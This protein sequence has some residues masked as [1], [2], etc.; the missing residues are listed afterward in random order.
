MLN[1]VWLILNIVNGE[2]KTACNTPGVTAPKASYEL[3]PGISSLDTA[4]IKASING[5]VLEQYQAILLDDPLLCDDDEKCLKQFKRFKVWLCSSN[6]CSGEE[7][8]KEPMKCF[9]E[10]E[11]NTSQEVTTQMNELICQL[12]KTPGSEARRALTSINPDIVEDG[13]VQYG[14]YL[15]AIKGSAKSCQDYIKEYIGAY[16][17]QWKHYWYAALSGCRILAKESTLE[18]EE[19]DFLLGFQQ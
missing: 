4:A 8:G 3:I 1:K 14:A 17:P 2:L 12:I 11:N 7:N 5:L 6:E 13:L 9:K 18:Q 16:G 10:I 15:M 19:K